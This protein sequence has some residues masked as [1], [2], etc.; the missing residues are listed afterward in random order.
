MTPLLLFCLV[1]AAAF[2]MLM[3]LVGVGVVGD[4]DAPRSM[5]TVIAFRRRQIVAAALVVGGVL[6]VAL[7][8]AAA[9][10][11]APPAGSNALAWLSFA[12]GAL[13]VVDKI[14]HTL[15]V[16]KPIVSAL[17]AIGT[18]AVANAAKTP[19]KVDDVVAAA[20][21]QALDQMAELLNIGKD[22]DALKML[23]DFLKA[24][25]GR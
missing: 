21:K 12:L 17:H 23:Q 19:S 11:T 7:P 8:A 14:A 16:M 1:A 2:V 25:A 9:E 6:F 20:E 10:A 24:R 3:R 4:L 18:T 5:P 15:G 13:I 22:A